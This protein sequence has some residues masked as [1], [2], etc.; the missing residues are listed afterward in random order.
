MSSLSLTLSTILTIASCTLELWTVHFQ[1]MSTTCFVG[2]WDIRYP[3]DQMRAFFRCKIARQLCVPMPSLIREESDNIVSLDRRSR[4]FL[5]GL[6]IVQA[7]RTKS[8]ILMLPTMLLMAGLAMTPMNQMY[9]IY[10]KLT[11]H[12]PAY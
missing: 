8:C 6:K 10:H 2:G 3:F 1:L 11:Q 9:M 12:T 4:R 5:C 7:S